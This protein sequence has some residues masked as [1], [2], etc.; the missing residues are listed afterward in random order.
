MDIE[1]MHVGIL[2]AR[3][4]WTEFCKIHQANLLRRHCELACEH[5]PIRL[6]L[7]A[8]SPVLADIS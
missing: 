4:Q 5:H 3:N 6:S 1:D 7:P 2:Q 8:I